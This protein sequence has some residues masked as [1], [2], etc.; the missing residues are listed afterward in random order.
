MNSSPTINL[1]RALFVVFAA[2]IGFRVGETFWGAPYVGIVAGAACGLMVVLAD[3]MLKGFSLRLF[4]CATFGLLLGFFASRLLLASGI[5]WDTSENIQ[6]LISLSIYATFGYIGMMLAVRSNRDE[7][8]FIIPYVRFRRERTEDPPVIVDSNIIIDGRLK[9]IAATGFVPSS[10]V[11]PHFVLEE[12]QTLADSHDPLK[13]ERGRTALNRLQEMQLDPGFSV[14]ITG[15]AL[16]PFA[17]VDS[18]LVQLA[19]M[20]NSRLLTNDSNLCSIARMQGV[21]ALNLNDLSRALRPTLTAGDEI[22]LVLSREGR[23]AHQAVGYLG[24]GTMIVVNHARAFLGKS[25]RVSISSVLQTSAGRM[26]F[27]ELKA[28]A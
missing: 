8:A 23:D 16:D 12:L 28:A 26:F 20:T 11:V 19:K 2:F 5:L 3:R 13:R 7:F 21:T 17:A 6:W 9:E 24:D 1:L 4:S 14:T 15:T 18:K 22:E 10:F 25:V 27:G